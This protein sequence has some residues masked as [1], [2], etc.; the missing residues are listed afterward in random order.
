MIYCKNVHQPFHNETCPF[1]SLPRHFLFYLEI[2]EKNISICSQFS[3]T[4]VI[5]QKHSH[6]G[7]WLW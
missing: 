5:D 2:Q 1:G 6:C 7:F 4:G 3:G